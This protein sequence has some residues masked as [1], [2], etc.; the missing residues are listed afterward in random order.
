MPELSPKAKKYQKQCLRSL[1]VQ[2]PMIST[3]CMQHS[4]LRK[5][6]AA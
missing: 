3:L 1:M 4:I 6:A 2:Q 5:M